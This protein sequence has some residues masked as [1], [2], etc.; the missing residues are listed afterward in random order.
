MIR[1]LFSIIALLML[2]ISNSH[3]EAVTV[4][5]GLDLNRYTG[6]WFEIARFPN[7]FQKQCAS[8]VDATYVMRTD[9]DINVTNRC[10]NAS[11]AIEEAV[12]RARVPNPETMAK[13]QVRFA[14]QWMT[15]LPMVWA[16]YWIVDLAP[17]YSVS[18][19]GDPTRKYLWILSRTPAIAEP[20]YNALMQRLVLQGYDTSKLVLTRQDVMK[21]LPASR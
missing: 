18:A 10:K 3:A 20:A 13:L 4:V 5:T 19:V 11:G 12:G 9:G 14:P 2:Y 21:Q 16:N 15:W 17:D 1:Q 7:K 8:H 6:K